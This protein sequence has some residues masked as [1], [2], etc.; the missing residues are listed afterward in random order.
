MDKENEGVKF[1]I[2]GQPG[3]S[4]VYINID[5][6]YNVNPNATK[7]ENTFIISSCDGSKAIAEV[8]GD[9]MKNVQ[10]APSA[11]VIDTRLVKAEIL[12]YV[13]RVRP[14]LVDEA[15]SDYVKMWDDI[16]NL[17]EVEALIY[18]PGK[19]KSTNFNRDLVAQIL[20]H[21]RLQKIYKV[22]YRQDYN[23][24]AMAKA[25]EQDKDHSVRRALREEPPQEVCDAIDRLLKEKYR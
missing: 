21:L 9:M 12:N 14:L 4:N 19:Q 15:K 3:T 24:S 25:L 5:T 13:S 1:K 11:L 2:E 8:T 16:L 20:Y 7:V 6:A 17:R 10:I 22:A 18:K 23:A